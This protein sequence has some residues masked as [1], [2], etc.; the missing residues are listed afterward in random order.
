MRHVPILSSALLV[1]VILAAC[2]TAAP[3]WTYMPAPSA[4]PAAS[5]A[6]SAGASAGAT[7]G[8]SAGASGAASAG[9]SGAASGAPSAGGSAS[10][11]VAQISAAGV[12]FEQTDVTVPAGA[13]FQIQFENKDAGT[14]HNVAI[15]QGDPTGPELFK[16]EIFPGVAKKTYDVPALPAGNYAFVCSVHPN[17]TGTL[18]VQ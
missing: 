10:T 18:T 14:P 16:G 15:H 11:D 3:G 9:P 2:S 7:A 17:M 8:A 12:K 6:G 13:P 1:A 4:T 5:T